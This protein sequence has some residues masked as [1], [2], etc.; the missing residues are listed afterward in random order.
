MKSLKSKL[1]QQSFLILAGVIIVIAV[2]S[3]TRTRNIIIEQQNN[4]FNTLFSEVQRHV[5]NRINIE[6]SGLQ[7]LANQDEIRDTSKPLKERALFL[8]RNVQ[9]NQGHRYLK[10]QLFF[11]FHEIP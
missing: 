2:S 3:A 4:N 6:Y 7:V 10:N 8:T 5:Q 1:M 9:E 11:R